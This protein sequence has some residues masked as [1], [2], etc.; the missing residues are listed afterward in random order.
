MANKT[1]M[2][3]APVAGRGIEF[4]QDEKHVYLRLPKDKTLG[5][6][7]ASGKMSIIASTANGWADIPGADGLRMNLNAGYRAEKG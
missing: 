6:P 4:A 5:K 7:S 1:E 2:T 3:F